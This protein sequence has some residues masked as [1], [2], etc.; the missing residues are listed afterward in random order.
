LASIDVDARRAA[1]DDAVQPRRGTIASLHFTHAAP[2]LLG[3]YRFDEI[4]FDA[5]AYFPVGPAVLAGHVQLGSI[6]ASDPTKVPFARRYFLGGATTLRGWGRYQVGPLDDQGLQ[7]GGRTLALLSAEARFPLRGKLTGV[8][9]VDAGNVGSS[10]WSVEKLRLRVDVGP[11]LRYQTPI[12]GAARRP[13][14]PAQSHRRPRHQWRTRAAVL[15]PSLEHRS[16]VLTVM[17]RRLCVDWVTAFW[18][19]SSSSRRPPSSS[20]PEWF[21]DR[22]RRF[23]VEWSAQYLNGQ[24]RSPA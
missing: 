2:W 9:F 11:G 15:A 14:I 18:P 24:L 23:A 10:D 19:S 8:V 4:M 22:I 12:G 3:S 7:I 17:R 1:V 16:G 6:G 5:R 13:R 21:K 20:N